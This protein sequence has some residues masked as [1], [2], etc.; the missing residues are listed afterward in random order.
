MRLGLDWDGTISCYGPELSQLARQARRVA[1]ITVNDEI[2]AVRAANALGIE[3][4]RV[5]VVVCPD[6]HI[7]RYDL[8]KAEV[9]LA[10][11]IDLMIDDDARVASACWAAGIP[12]LLVVERSPAQ[13]L[14]R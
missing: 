4:Q 12:A 7:E 10:L 13:V 9:C 3:V 11:Q 5:D 14:R 1:V 2:T 6:E 8:W